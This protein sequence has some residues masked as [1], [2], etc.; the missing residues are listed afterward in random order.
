M[1]QIGS[2]YRIFGREV[3]QKR[4]QI[5]GKAAALLKKVGQSMFKYLEMLVL[6]ILAEFL[7]QYTSNSVYFKFVDVRLCYIVI[8][9]TTYGMR[10]GILGALLECLV[11]V[12]QYAD[13][14]VNGTLLFYNIENWIP[15]V[16][17][18]MTGSITGYVKNKKTDELE[19]AHAEYNL[20]RNKYLFLNDVYHGAMQNK[21]EYKRQILGYKDSFGKIFDAVQKLDNE[22]PESIFL[23]GLQIMEDI[24][25]K[26]ST[27]I[28]TL[29]SWQRFW[30]LA[31]CSSSQ[32]TKLS[33]S[34]RIEDYQELYTVVKK[35][36]VWKNSELQEGMPMY[37]CG[38]FN[39]GVLAL[40]I[41]RDKVLLS[42]SLSGMVRATDT[43]GSDESGALYL[44][45]VQMSSQNFPIVGEKLKNKGIEYQLVEKVG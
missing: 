3:Y 8:I 13:I 35:G 31:V 37:A 12:R 30:R 22:L 33:K 45:L 28:Y 44:L 9:G 11:L 1:E 6:F 7:S 24:M 20:L 25:E 38:V 27:A 19:F 32:L 5:V 16:V 2:Y 41:I 10:M 40:L 36:E 23:E 43:L 17:Y 4:G 18:L 15:F 21:G 14:G 39:N 34:I 29:D 26:H 42:E